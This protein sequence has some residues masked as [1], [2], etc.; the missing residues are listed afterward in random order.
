MGGLREW[1]KTQVPPE[2]R[3]S[4]QAD[5]GVLPAT[6]FPHSPRWVSG[7]GKLWTQ[8]AGAGQG[9]VQGLW[10]SR[11]PEITGSRSQSRASQTPLDTAEELR[12]KWGPR[13][14]LSHSQ[15][16]REERG[17]WVVP[18][19]ARVL[20]LVHGWSAGR[21]S[22]SWLFSGKPIPSFKCGMPW[23]TETVNGFRALLYIERQRERKREANHG[24]VERGRKG[25][26]EGELEMRVLRS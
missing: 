12:T 10:A 2:F 1:E 11:R 7:C 20:G 18:T 9:A 5:A 19:W 8:P 15:G 25:E 6:C 4:G 16:W 13:G 26:R 22:G 17:C 21:P 24:H 23:W 14:W 3:C